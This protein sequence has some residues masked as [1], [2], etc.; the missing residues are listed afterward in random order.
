MT[1]ER[2]QY[3]RATHGEEEI[4]AVVKVLRS[5]SQGLRIG[6]NVKEMETRVAEMSGKKYGVMVNSG[7]SGLYVAVDLLGGHAEDPRGDPG[8]DVGALVESTAAATSGGH[9]GVGPVGGPEHRPH[10]LADVS[11]GVGARPVV[12]EVAG[13]GRTVPV[14][15]GRRRIASGQQGARG[16]RHAAGEG[17]GEH[18]A[19]CEERTWRSRGAV[20][21]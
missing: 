19:T 17:A 15:V 8:M 1:Q 4:E 10:D 12:S 20:G 3:A 18:P 16:E 13:V 5:G 7:S 6:A 2:I 21:C 11:F 9:V 14:G